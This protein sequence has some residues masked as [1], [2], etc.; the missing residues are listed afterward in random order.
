MITLLNCKSV[1]KKARLLWV[2]GCYTDGTVLLCFACF[3]PFFSDPPNVYPD[4][5]FF[6]NF[7][8]CQLGL[9]A[10]SLP[11]GLLGVSCNEALSLALDLMITVLALKGIS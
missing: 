6:F 7:L 9:A 2:C 3:S 1:R 10:F 8:C 4:F 5:F 11:P